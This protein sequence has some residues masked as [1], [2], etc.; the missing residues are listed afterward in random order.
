VRP[1]TAVSDHRPGI[2]PAAVE[3]IDRT[4]S[5]GGSRGASELSPADTILIVELDGS[6]VG[7]A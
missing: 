7:G 6:G 5:R 2:I 1:E 4:D 3:M